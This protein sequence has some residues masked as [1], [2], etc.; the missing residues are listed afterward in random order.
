MTR[1]RTSSNESL[2]STGA[3]VGVF[4]Y[5][6]LAVAKLLGASLYHSIALRADGLN[7]LTDIITSLIVY[8][9]LRIARQPVDDNHLFGHE[10]YEAVTSFLVGIMM[11]LVSIDIIHTGW[12]AIHSQQYQAVDISAIW[13][14][15]ISVIILIGAYLYIHYLYIRTH[16]I[17]LNATRQDM[18]NDILLTLST[19]IGII[20]AHFNLAWLDSVIAIG[21][22]G[23]ITI[24]SLR[25]LKDSTDILTDSFNHEALASYRET[26]LQH[27]K[28]HRIRSIRARHS[29]QTTY[30]DVTVQVDIHLNVL[31]AHQITEEIEQILRYN[32]G[33]CDV[34][35]HVEPYINNE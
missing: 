13:V 19:A 17:A 35:V 32:Y 30:I 1:Q 29:G 5:L 24:S 18:R 9:G 4:V 28:V 31:E 6:F 7:N 11:F 8:I 3:S 16:S 27:P 25:L 34:D 23:I 26:I 15:I 20:G 21:V 12:Q 33:V 2:A 22:G 10:K 14:P